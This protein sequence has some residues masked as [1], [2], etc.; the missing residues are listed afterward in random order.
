MNGEAD[1]LDLPVPVRDDDLPIPVAIPQQ[2]IVSAKYPDWTNWASQ[3][4]V[5]GLAMDSR[6]G[7]LWLAT[8]GGVLRWRTELDRFTRYGSEHGLPGNAVK[9]VTVGG[10]GQVWAVHDR[11]GLSYLDGETWCPYQPLWEASISCLHVAPNGQLW[12]GSEGTIYALHSPS[13]A[14]MQEIPF[15]G[16]PPRALA[17]TDGGELWLCN[18]EGVYKHQEHDWVRYTSQPDILTLACQGQNLW[19]G[20]VEGLLRVDLSTGELAPAGTWPRSEISALAPAAQG[21]WAAC[22]RYVGLATET[23]WMPIKGKACDRITSLAPAGDGGVWMGT[24][25]GLQHG[26]R[27]SIRFHLTESPPDVIIFRSPNQGKAGG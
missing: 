19:L 13:E 23:G 1:R 6:R 9:A 17:V 16:I 3:G 7:E 5:R 15:A 8:G 10:T 22:E 24:H 4:H 18:A 2:E 14:P 27:D 21:V 11:G 20:T 26:S 12:L 25:S